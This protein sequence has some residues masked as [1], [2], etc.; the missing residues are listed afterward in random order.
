[1][2]INLAQYYWGRSIYVCA[3]GIQSIQNRNQSTAYLLTEKITPEGVA[4]LAHM[5]V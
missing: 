4:G 1:M 3:T 2:Y 5:V